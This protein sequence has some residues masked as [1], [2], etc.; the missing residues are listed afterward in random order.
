MN[1]LWLNLAL[2]ETENPHHEDLDGRKMFRCR[3]RLHSFL[4]DYFQPSRMI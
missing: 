1:W 3:C 4:F 2:A